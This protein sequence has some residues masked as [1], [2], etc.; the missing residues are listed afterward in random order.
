M[1]PGIVVV[2]ATEGIETVIPVIGRVT[3]RK[4][5]WKI[6][7]NRAGTDKF[8]DFQRSKVYLPCPPKILTHEIVDTLLKL[9]DLVSW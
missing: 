5:I 6:R 8:L 1:N 7:L 4:T 9:G 2:G 3:L